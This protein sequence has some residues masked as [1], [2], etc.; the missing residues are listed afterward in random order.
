MLQ[1]ELLLCI[2]TY[3]VVWRVVT[4]CRELLGLYSTESYYADYTIIMLF[5]EWL[6][7]YRKYG[8][9]KVIKLSKEF[10]LW[11]KSVYLFCCVIIMVHWELLAIWRIEIYYVVLRLNMLYRKLLMCMH[12]EFLGCVEIVHGI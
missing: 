12:G 9:L 7:K 6:C 3:Y 1:R 8:V 2:E 10:L 11:V 5:C 4:L